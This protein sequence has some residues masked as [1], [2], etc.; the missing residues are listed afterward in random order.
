M[1]DPYLSSFISSVAEL[2]RGEYKQSNYGKV[3]LPFTVLELA[4]R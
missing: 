3:I 4:S 2:L 1:A